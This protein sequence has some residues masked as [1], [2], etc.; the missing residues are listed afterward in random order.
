MCNYDNRRVFQAFT[1]QTALVTSHVGSKYD[2]GVPVPTPR[3]ED[4]LTR[5]QEQQSY[6]RYLKEPSDIATERGTSPTVGFLG[7]RDR[8]SGRREISSLGEVD[9]RICLL[10][11]RTKLFENFVRF[12]CPSY[13]LSTGIHLSICVRQ[14]PQC[15]SDPIVAPLFSPEP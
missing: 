4:P 2:R 13:P 3:D 15:L 1:R 10:S 5:D 12:S 8:K 14:I 11:Y 7:G 6:L 9:Q